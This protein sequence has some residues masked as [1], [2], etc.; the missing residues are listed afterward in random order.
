MIPGL[1]VGS[2]AGTCQ[3]WV[4]AG[5]WGGCHPP[6][7]GPPAPRSVWL[8]LVLGGNKAA[9]GAAAGTAAR[10]L[11]LIGQDADLLVGGLGSSLAHM[12]C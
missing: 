7:G 8:A 6:E 11:R 10:L 3:G 1:S 4:T 9:Y 12:F 5:L 2:W